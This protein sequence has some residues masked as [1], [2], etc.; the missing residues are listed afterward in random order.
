NTVSK[1]HFVVEDL[2]HFISETT[3][4]KKAYRTLLKKFNNNE[5]DLIQEF[6]E[7]LNKR[8]VESMNMALFINNNKS[9]T[10][11]GVKINL[12]YPSGSITHGDEL[13]EENVF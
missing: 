4:N 8:V 6:Q 2:K 13:F 9:V 10:F 7:I 5:Q 1:L 3:L 11:K 12:F